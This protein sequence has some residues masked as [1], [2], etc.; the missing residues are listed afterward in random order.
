MTLKEIIDCPFLIYFYNNLFRLTQIL[1]KTPLLGQHSQGPLSST[2]SVLDYLAIQN[3]TVKA[4]LLTHEVLR[5]T[6]NFA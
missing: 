6:A 1:G 5:V 4:L 2:V 3:T